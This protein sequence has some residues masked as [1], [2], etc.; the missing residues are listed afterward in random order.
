MK[1]RDVKQEYQLQEWRGMLRERKESG[2]SV[3]E[4]CRERGLAEHVYYY[5]LRKL[6]QASADD[7]GRN[8]GD[9]GCRPWCIGSGIADDAPC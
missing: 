2:L 6:R 7:K 4:W 3:K 8:A 9:S 1:I 5:R